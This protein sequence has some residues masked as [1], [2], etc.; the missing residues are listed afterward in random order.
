METDEQ[1]PEYSKDDLDEAFDDALAAA[2]RLHEKLAS[3]AEEA[4]YVKEAIK[5]ARPR[6]DGLYKRAHDDPS[7]YQIIASGINFLRGL[8]GELDRLSGIADDF[9]VPFGPVVNSTGSFG[10]TV[11]AASALW[12]IDY[13][14]TQPL[15]PPPSRK[16]RREY[17]D[18]LRR[19]DPSLAQS[20]D[21]IWQSYLGTTSDPHRAALFMIRTLLDNFFAKIAPDDEVRRSA[22]WHEKMGDNPNQIWRSERIAYALE[23][24]IKDKIRQTMLQA[25]STQIGALYKA[26]NQAHDRGALNE[27]KASKALT[28]VDDFLKD[29]LDALS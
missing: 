24:N 3:A 20:Y 19:I 27:E 12:D 22:H 4:G 26:V 14:E 10:G 13:V 18:K 6:F 28:A 25:Q 7:A 8:G 21:Q 9:S 17:S 2:E 11:D 29:W 15:S 16:S 1:L 5:Y 23:K